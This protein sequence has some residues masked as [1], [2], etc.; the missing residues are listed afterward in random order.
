MDMTDLGAQILHE[1]K[2]N[3]KVTAEEL[4][5]R[6]IGSSVTEVEFIMEQIKIVQVE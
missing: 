5:E 1:M 6:G 4:V 2:I 3:W